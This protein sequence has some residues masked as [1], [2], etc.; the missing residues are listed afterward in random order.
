MVFYRILLTFTFP[1]Q[2]LTTL[3]LADDLSGF[4]IVE[5]KK[6]KD[7]NPSEFRVWTSKNGVSKITAKVLKISD[8][9]VSL[10]L[11]DGHELEVQKSFLSKED[12]SFIQK[13]QL[14]ENTTSGVD[15]KS[16]RIWKSAQGSEIVGKLTEAT[17]KYVRIKTQADRLISIKH[18]LLSDH[19]QKL[20][21]Q[22]IAGLKRLTRNDC[23]YM[24][25]S[26]KWR[27]GV[28]KDWSI[29]YEFSNFRAVDGRKV[30]DIVVSYGTRQKGSWMI[31]DEGNLVISTNSGESFWKFPVSKDDRRVLTTF[32]SGFY[33]GFYP[34]SILY[35]VDDF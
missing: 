30:V 28:G 11:D 18:E 14:I 2:I 6:E 34:G 7:F 31:N 16:D 8:S 21:S 17:D 26:K 3:C 35:P 13:Y 25:R 24:L 32:D 10:L 9:A 23:E 19:D 12:L 4:G 27:D 5:E 15:L 22:H 29:Q 33:S 20:I 1:S